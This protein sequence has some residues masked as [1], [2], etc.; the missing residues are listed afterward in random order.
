MRR[1]G[2]IEIEG[3]IIVEAAR[4][5]EYGR[6]EI[7]IHYFPPDQAGQIHDIPFG[8]G[9]V[10]LDFKTDRSQDLLDPVRVFLPVFL[11]NPVKETPYF[12]LVFLGGD[13]TFP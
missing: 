9:N 2:A 8:P 1:L 5:F 11:K 10:P 6:F 12:Y 4:R 3:K 7:L 13:T